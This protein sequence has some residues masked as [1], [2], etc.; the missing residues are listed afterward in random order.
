M[1]T[2]VVT[3]IVVVLALLVVGWWYWAMMAPIQNEQGLIPQESVND[4]AQSDAEI[5][6]ALVGTWESTEDANFVRAF[7]AN[8]TVTDS[9][10]GIENATVT[11]EWS[12]VTDMSQAPAGLP[13][14]QDAQV[15]RIQF[16]E[17]ALYFAITN[18]SETE[19][20]MIYLS[21]NGVLEFRRI[22]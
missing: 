9:Y 6:A 11:G 17:E 14:I 3:G 12:L 19:L 10:E 20:S 1:N 22:N 15:L 13:V 16:P 21:G 5:N 8:G 18:L 2:K 7:N 4:V